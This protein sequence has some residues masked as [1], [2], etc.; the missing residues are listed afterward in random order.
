MGKT[1]L[2]SKHLRIA[3]ATGLSA[4]MVIAFGLVLASGPA[5][6]AVVNTSQQQ[7]P[8][9]QTGAL[10]NT[11]APTATTGSTSTS[12]TTSKSS[13][14]Q[15]QQ[16][17][18]VTTPAPSATDTPAATATPSSTP[19]DTP[20]PAPTATPV[21]TWHT[22]G[23]WSGTTTTYETTT[24]VT[25]HSTNGMV[26]MPWSC[27]GGAAQIVFTSVATGARVAYPAGCGAYPATTYIF[28]VSDYIGYGDYRLTLEHDPHYTG[29][30]G[31]W[32][33]TVEAWY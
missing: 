33:A 31:P 26:R 18:Q 3:G 28:Q 16:A 20:T 12:K 17:P 11:S 22:L 7:Q 19:T 21:P 23:T 25:L 9:S 1:G 24:L 2:N 29:P 8:Q 5:S 30:F 15:Q 10:L 13:T 32:T 14:T 4:L 6:G 27:E